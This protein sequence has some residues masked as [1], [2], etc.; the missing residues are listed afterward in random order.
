M[1]HIL[2]RLKGLEQRHNGASKNT[3]YKLIKYHTV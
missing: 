1:K 2:H 3:Q